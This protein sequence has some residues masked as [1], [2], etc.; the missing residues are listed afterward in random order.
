MVATG[1]NI[2]VIVHVYVDE[3]SVQFLLFTYPVV[4][5][6][7]FVIQ[8]PGLAY[9]F[10]VDHFHKKNWS[11]Y[12]TLSPINPFCLHP[13]KTVFCL[14]K[15]FLQF[16]T[17]PCQNIP[18]SL[19][20]YSSISPCENIPLFQIVKIFLHCENILPS[21]QNFSSI[22]PCQN[23]PQ[24]L[25]KYSSILPCQNTPPSSQKYSSI[26][27]IIFLHFTLPKYFC[28]PKYSLP[29]SSVSPCQSI[30]ESLPKYSWS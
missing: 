12:D 5:H 10:D 26:L 4:Q 21:L 20:K 30:P 29:H 18:P 7:T 19:Q 3:A 25:R 9:D 24:S 14:T 22:S 28:I 13:G 2:H 8:S 17:S 23:I 15:I 1:S 16:T 6:H 11:S 27:A